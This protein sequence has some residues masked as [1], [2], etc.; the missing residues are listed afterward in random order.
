MKKTLAIDFDGVIHKYSL[1]WQDGAIYD[2][3]MAGCKEALEEL[4]KDYRIIIFSTR[5]STQ[6]G[7]I[8]SWLRKH[9]LMEYISGVTDRKPIAWLLVDDRAL[10]FESWQQ[11]LKGVGRLAKQ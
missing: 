8:W 11:A 7:D 10:R 1:G 2:P 5:A 3:P 9:G 4:S 6:K